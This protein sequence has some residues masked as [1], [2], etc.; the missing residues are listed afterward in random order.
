MSTTIFRSEIQHN[1]EEMYQNWLADHP[2]GFVVN[3]L[4]NTKAQGSEND[5]RFT[6]IHRVSCKS[7]NPLES[8]LDKAGFTTG[9]Y[10]KA[11]TLTLEDAKKEGCAQTGL[12]SIKCCPCV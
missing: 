12:T 4:K 5:D 6:R 11:C 3:F 9:L 10:Q 1:S 7:I 8:N 2:D